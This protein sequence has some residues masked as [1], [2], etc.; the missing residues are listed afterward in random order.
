MFRVGDW[1][2]RRPVDR[3]DVEDIADI[4]WAYMSSGFGKTDFD[5][6]WLQ[7]YHITG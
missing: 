5:R 3:G 1:I 4:S 7:L 2:A 6:L